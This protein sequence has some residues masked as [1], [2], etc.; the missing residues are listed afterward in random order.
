MKKQTERHLI[1]DLINEQTNEKIQRKER[2]R[3]IKRQKLQQQLDG[4][5]P[6]FS[7]K[8]W[9]ANSFIMKAKQQQQSPSSRTPASPSMRSESPEN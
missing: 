2:Y 1:E 9:R 7:R 6:Q 3:K 8:L 4:M 5:S